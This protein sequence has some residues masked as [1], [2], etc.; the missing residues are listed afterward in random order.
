MRINQTL[1]ICQ[2]IS[3]TFLHLSQMHSFSTPMF[4]PVKLHSWHSMLEV[5]FMLCTKFE[6]HLSIWFTEFWRLAYYIFCRILLT[7]F[8]LSCALHCI[9][10]KK[11]SICASHSKCTQSE[12]DL[13]VSSQ[14]DV[15]MFRILFLLLKNV[16]K[17]YSLANSWHS[18]HCLVLS[19]AF[20][21]RTW[22]FVR[23]IPIAPIFLS[24]NVTTSKEITRSVSR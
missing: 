3:N 13:L 22:A 9:W 6:A 19:I 10:E 24:Y 16:L 1:L 2:L 17:I 7:L 4:C 8:T 18:W 20:E 21:K 14:F 11:R 15:T 12:A 23:L 5:N